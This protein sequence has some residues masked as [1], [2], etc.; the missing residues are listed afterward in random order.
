MGYPTSL[1][2]HTM[3]QVLQRQGGLSATSGSPPFRHYKASCTF[4]TWPQS[5]G[6][7]CTPCL[8][9]FGGGCY[10]TFL[11]QRASKLGCW[12]YHDV[13]KEPNDFTIVGPPVSAETCCEGVY[14]YDDYGLSRG[15]IPQ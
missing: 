6:I 11:E 2:V 5:F 8:V 14:R 15:E 13:P 4:A 9:G 12:P 3:L 7:Y 1:L 10:S